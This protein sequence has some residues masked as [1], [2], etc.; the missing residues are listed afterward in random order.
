MQGRIG[1]GHVVSER[2]MVI[3]RGKRTYEFLAGHPVDVAPEDYDEL[4]SL[5]E[6][7]SIHIDSGKAE[8]V[9]SGAGSVCLSLCT[10]NPLVSVVI[11]S[12]N[13]GNYI[14]DAISS[15]REQSFKD[16]E[17]VIV[18]SGSTDNSLDIAQ[19]HALSDK[20]ITIVKLHENLGLSFARNVG[21]N[22]ARG[23]LICMLDADDAFVPGRL[24]FQVSKFLGDESLDFIHGDAETMDRK[25]HPMMSSGDADYE[26]MLKRDYIPACSVMFKAS[27]ARKVGLYD[28]R[29]PAAEDWDLYLRIIASGAKCKYFP[30]ITYRYRVHGES[31]TIKDSKYINNP[32]WM[33]GIRDKGRV[34][35]EGVLAHRYPVNLLFTMP[36]AGIGGAGIATWKL[37][38]RLDRSKYN[39]FVYVMSGHTGSAI[40]DRLDSIGVPCVIQKEQYKHVP[41][42]GSR[43]DVNRIKKYMTDNNIGL[44]HNIVIVAARVAAE[45]LEIPVVQMRHQIPYSMDIKSSESHVVI[46]DLALRQC[47]MFDNS[48]LIYNGIDTAKFCCDFPAGSRFRNENGIPL[49]AKVV[50]W[51]GRMH[52]DKGPD[53]MYEVM[54][55]LPSDVYGIVVYVE[56]NA[57]YSSCINDLY[58]RDNIVMRSNVNHDDMTQIYS[59][60][61]IVLNTSRTEGNGLTLMEGMACQ[62]VPIAFPVG[63]IPEI[64]TTNYNGILLP[65]TSTMIKTIRSL[66]TGKIKSMGEIAR[67]T[68]VRRFSLL[69]MVD[70]FESVY[71]ETLARCGK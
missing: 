13:Y 9:V 22:I 19:K 5:P 71:S 11:T 2:S 69:D 56:D 20:R 55:N 36:D 28:S 63:G 4:V 65:D 12:Y 40:K 32:K 8:E 6:I 59:T 44:L 31:K 35:R 58:T 18:D 17:L 47:P 7:R 48:Y 57:R 41:V 39:P 54:G 25:S 49:D 24:E 45:E 14:S 46:C 37:I 30:G 3:R 64:I 67:S 29:I 53:L 70:R 50:L 23:N 68:V 1:G 52:S 43:P 66:S 51:A 60:S 62:C 34:V 26:G 42:T 16:W 27:A 15:V 33:D 21:V 10:S 38:S 61:D